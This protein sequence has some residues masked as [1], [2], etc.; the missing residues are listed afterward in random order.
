MKSLLLLCLTLCAFT[1]RLT[2]Q[3]N[4]VNNLALGKMVFASSSE[5]GGTL[6]ENAVDGNP[7]TRWSSLFSDP[8]YIY[9]D[10][11][12]ITS[13][14]EVVLV[15][16]SAYAT[17][18]Q[19]DISNDA[20][21]WTTVATV[22]GN[23]SLTNIV[24]VTGNGRYVRMMGLTRA[25]SFGYSLYEFRVYGSAATPFCSLNLALEQPAFASSE[26][27][28]AFP[29]MDAFDGLSGTRWSSH[30]NDAEYIYV[31]L[32]AKFPLCSVELE[33]ESAYATSYRIDLSDDAVN[34]TTEAT[35]TGNTSTTNTVP[36]TGNARYVRMFGLTRATGFGYSLFEMKV[37][38]NSIVLPVKWISFTAKLDNSKKVNLDWTTANETNNSYYEVQRKAGADA[39][40]TTVGIVLSQSGNNG[41]LHYAFTDNAAKD[42]A[43]YY[44]IRQVDQDG[45]FSYSKTISIESRSTSSSISIYPNPVANQLYVKD[46]TQTID[47]VRVFSPDGRKLQEVCC[48]AKGQLATIQLGGYPS[49]TYLVQVVT[50]KMVETRKVVKE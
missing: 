2:A 31:D 50:A 14:C 13:L 45:N 26:E 41:N 42:G 7:G 5:N 10:L 3:C 21:D 34:W 27:S 43:N 16:E 23:S 29:A 46:P 18:F 36:I 40:F 49:G 44:R 1:A 20:S 15:W 37:F 24:P 17:S 38:G 48:I 4:T 12:A 9:V 6:P 47:Y 39:D 35:I 25:G 32:G 22:T 33:W 19:I 8:Q 28:I 30:F 11:G